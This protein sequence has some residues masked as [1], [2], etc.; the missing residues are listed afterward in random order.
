MTEDGTQE[1]DDVLSWAD[2]LVQALPAAVSALMPLIGERIE[3]GTL[4]VASGEQSAV[5]FGWSGSGSRRVCSVHAARELRSVVS[6]LGAPRALSPTHWL[7]WRL[8][9]IFPRSRSHLAARP[10]CPR[11]A[12]PILAPASNSQS[13]SRR[14]PLP[15]S[16]GRGPE[17]PPLAPVV[18]ARLPSPRP[19]QIL[20]VSPRRLPRW[21]PLHPPLRR[22]P[23]PG[24]PRPER[25]PRRV[26]TPRGTVG[27]CLGGRSA[28]RPPGCSRGDARCGA[29]PVRGPRRGPFRTR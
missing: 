3:C 26:R 17:G 23:P 4:G 29:I 5:C 25:R 14:T 13:R 9:C 15:V 11:V 6:Y 20:H 18:A 16:L 21:R 28:R 8:R 10:R 1:A 12:P 24:G 2:P 22:S 7:R 19:P 27:V